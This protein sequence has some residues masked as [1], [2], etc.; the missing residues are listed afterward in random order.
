MTLS[1]SLSSSTTFG[2]YSAARGISNY[3]LFKEFRCPLSSAPTVLLPSS[4]V[5]LH[6]GLCCSFPVVSYR[7]RFV[8]RCVVSCLV[9]LYLVS[10]CLVL[11]FV[12]FCS[13]VF[14]NAAFCQLS[15]ILVERIRQD[16]NQETCS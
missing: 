3:I 16:L 14:V 10:S 11:A 4:C 12:F 7:Y 9:L 6:G 15:T 8:P 2:T 1:L 5:C 13:D